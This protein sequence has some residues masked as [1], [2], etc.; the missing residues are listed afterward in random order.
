MAS[1][2]TAVTDSDAFSSDGPGFPIPAF[3][4]P[5]VSTRV[6]AHIHFWGNA[7]LV[8]DE[9]DAGDP[10]VLILH[11][12]E[13]DEPGTH[14]DRAVEFAAALEQAGVPHVFIR[15][16]GQGHSAWNYRENW[17]GLRQITHSFLTDYFL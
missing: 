13:D 12:T 7:M 15:A 8:L 9:I 14:F 11:G 16:E 17:Q 5:G 6:Q 1:V 3:N 10:P 4:N 2:A